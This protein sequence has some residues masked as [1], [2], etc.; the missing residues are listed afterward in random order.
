MGRNGLINWHTRQRPAPRKP[1]LTHFKCRPL[2][3]NAGMA[4]EQ[5][6]NCGEIRGRFF[7]ADGNPIN[8]VPNP[9]GAALKHH[10]L[11]GQHQQVIPRRHG[12]Q[13]ASQDANEQSSIWDLANTKHAL[14]RGD[15]RRYRQQHHA[16]P[17]PGRKPI[18]ARG[19]DPRIGGYSLNADAHRFA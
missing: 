5:D 7:L 12:A 2:H 14:E 4:F 6:I 15:A 8:Q 10:T 19:H 9:I 1:G 11:V 18:P 3:Q 17:D 16:W 13:N